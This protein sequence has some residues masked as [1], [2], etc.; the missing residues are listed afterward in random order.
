[1]VR[2]SEE[3]LSH[4]WT[5]TR[6][7]LESSLARFVY[8]D[9]GG[10]PLQNHCLTRKEVR[11]QGCRD[12]E[13]KCQLIEAQNVSDW[14][15]TKRISKTL[16][17]KGWSHEKFGENLPYESKNILAFLLVDIETRV[18]K[19]SSS[20]PEPMFPSTLHLTILIPTLEPVELILLS[21]IPWSLIAPLGFCYCP[22]STR[23]PDWG[24]LVEL[25]GQQ[26]NSNIKS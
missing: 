11:A 12:S 3:T 17:K 15:C 7:S 21:V 24:R 22:R 16:M 25:E 23:L 8:I 14:G 5:L 13:L 1:M 20:F 4:P 19:F 18:N 26:P 9:R 2:G 6:H 10:Q